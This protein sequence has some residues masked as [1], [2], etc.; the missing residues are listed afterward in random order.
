LDFRRIIDNLYKYL[1]LRTMKTLTFFLLIILLSLIPGFLLN[2]QFQLVANINTSLKNNGSYPGSF[3]KYNG[4]I[5]FGAQDFHGIGIWKTDGTEFGTEQV[6]NKVTMREAILYKDHILFIGYD[7]SHY[8]GLWLSDGTNDGTILLHNFNV[9]V[10]QSFNSQLTIVG[11]KVAFRFYNINA[12][13]GLWITNGTIEG[14]KILKDPELKDASPG[15]LTIFKDKLL[16]IADDASPGR[17]LWISDGSPVG[18]E[19]IQHLNLSEYPEPYG[20]IEYRSKIYFI[21][22]NDTCFALFSTDGTNT[23][24]GITTVL[25]DKLKPYQYSL[26][27]MP[28]IV[29][30]NDTLYFSLYNT[31]PELVFSLWKASGASMVKVHEFEQST[32]WIIGLFSLPDELITVVANPFVDYA[33]EHLYL[34]KLD[35]YGMHNY[36]DIHYTGY[37][38]REFEA[39]VND[40]VI[41][42]NYEH[43][44]W[45]TNGTDSGTTRITNECYL[46][47]SNINNNKLI[48]LFDG[49]LYF[50]GWIDSIS[51]EPWISDGTAAGTRLIKDVNQSIRFDGIEDPMIAGEKL[52]FKGTIP[53][54]GKEL[55]VSDGT[56]SGTL[57]LKDINPGES[58]SSP[59]SFIEFDGSL[60]FT[61]NEGPMQS[62][63]GAIY[64]SGLWKT[65][66]SE[67]G[68][69]KIKNISTR[70]SSSIFPKKECPDKV[71]L[72]D[73][74]LFTAAIPLVFDSCDV[75]LWESDGT[76]VGTR[77]LKNIDPAVDMANVFGKPNL[78][79][80]AGNLVFFAA[81]TRE[82]GTELWKTDGTTEGTMMVSDLCSGPASSLSYYP[83][84]S[85]LITFNNSL[86]FTPFDSIYGYE[87]WISDGSEQGTHLIRDINPGT[88][89]TTIISPL[90]VGNLMFFGTDDGIHGTELWKTDGTEAGTFLVKDI[91][92]SGS[93]FMRSIG[94]FNGTYFFLGDDSIHGLELWKSDGTPEGTS[95]FMDAN[96]GASSGGAGSFLSFADR[97]IF[98]ATDE[99]RAV[100]LWAS[101]GR[102]GGTEKAENWPSSKIGYINKFVLLNNSIYFAAYYEDY[103][104]ALF[105]YD[106]T[107]LPDLNRSLFLEKT[108][109][110]CFGENNGSVDLQ[111]LFGQEPYSYYWSTGATTEDIAGL[112]PGLYYVAVTDANDSTVTDSIQIF[113]PNPLV[114]EIKNISPPSYYGFS[115][116]HAKVTVLGGSP[117]YYYL[118]DD[119][120]C[121]QQ[122]EAYG[123]KGNT[124]YHVQIS[125]RNGCS[126]S[127]SVLTFES[128]HLYI[129]F[130]VINDLTCPGDTDGIVTA[131][132]SYAVEPLTW[133]W[134]D[135]ANS[136]D[137]VIKN[138]SA[139]MI[140]HVLITDA[141]GNTGYDSVYLEDPAPIH[142]DSLLIGD[143]KP[144][145][146]DTNGSITVVVNMGSE[147]LQYSIDEG[148][149]FLEDW[150]FDN[151]A[152]GEYSIIIKDTNNCLY[153]SDNLK[154]HQP[155][156][157]ESGLITGDDQINKDETASYSTIA[158]PGSVYEWFISGGNVIN[159]QGT[160]LVNVQW[161][162]EGIGKISYVETDSNGCIG[163]TVSLVVEIFTGYFTPEKEQINIFPNPFSDKAIIQLPIS[164]NYCYDLVITDLTGKVIRSIGKIT[165]N[166]YELDRENLPS[167]LYIIE[168][169]GQDIYRGKIII[170]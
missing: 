137:S 149:T 52:Y 93:G 5:F 7:P 92:P 95:L 116:A 39:V 135:P 77:L 42:F 120:D 101:D 131:F 114:S 73:K 106:L 124:K 113:E 147:S 54:Y 162:S 110:K 90:T 72:G 165:G 28:E 128:D 47:G 58:S 123:L 82:T 40:T 25:P 2:A 132:P 151:L 97:F 66:G 98:T 134:D 9:N 15:N 13:C 104:K 150:Y 152:A 138:I 8:Y 161:V 51:D 81:T 105:S 160:D 37:N 23:G 27:H 18:T 143:V 49:N 109:V 158:K 83:E 154:V 32:N 125:D 61:A 100:N 108:D 43:I 164:R 64:P 68:T 89:N 50:S 127:D 48:F 69:V 22:K 60:Y 55:W 44:I 133:L 11:D 117:P 6:T 91:N 1:K 62:Y 168:L 126:T 14:T 84:K 102:P 163:D 142:I 78:Y 145:F 17:A 121:T 63:I 112:S 16:F 67:S 56:T 3:I 166:S 136:T 170:E 21:A 129:M 148:N 80:P 119:P 71:R 169:R 45:K 87:L 74:F 34:W 24:T 38:T 10:D 12:E 79:T 86:I 139:D 99:N 111:V 4:S 30:F 57:L 36:Y 75:E 122:S 107:G 20:F 159:G 141:I 118:W 46:R 53:P 153:E 144:C 94:E 29:I 19:I 156:K 115:D 88:A 31:D 41:Y 76:A 85:N 35:S 70:F 155:E 146:G 167:G 59:E 33:T 130:S 103:G 157:I 140:Y 65:D 96:P 26:Y